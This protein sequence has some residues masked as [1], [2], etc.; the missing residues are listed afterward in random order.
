MSC[1]AAPHLCDL[2]VLALVVVSLVKEEALLA[3]TQHG[4]ASA[5]GQQRGGRGPW[6]HHRL[7]LVHL[8]LAAGSGGVCQ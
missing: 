1:H 3:H 7:V 5:G 8:Q 2:E 4:R 6:A